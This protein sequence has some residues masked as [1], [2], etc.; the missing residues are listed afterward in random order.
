MLGAA[1]LLKLPATEIADVYKLG[2]L[3]ASAVAV[4]FFKNKDL[5]RPTY[6]CRTRTGIL[7]VFYKV[8][9]DSREDLYKGRSVVA[10][11][12]RLT[13]IHLEPPPR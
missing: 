9:Q 8:L 5:L 10:K 7:S 12:K 3:A 2:L 1:E 4:S 11:K 13:H 6:S